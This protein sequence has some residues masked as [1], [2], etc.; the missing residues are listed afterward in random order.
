M[1]KIERFRTATLTGKCSAYNAPMIQ[2]DN[3][4]YVR[5]ESHIEI[6]RGVEAELAALK[7]MQ[8]S[9]FFYH[10]K[11]IFE[12]AFE[13]FISAMVKQASQPVFKVDTEALIAADV[14][15]WMERNMNE[16]AGFATG[17]LFVGAVEVDFENSRVKIDDALIK[18][19]VVG[20]SQ[21]F[22]FPTPKNMVTCTVA[23][24]GMP[25]TIGKNYAFD[26]KDAGLIR[27]CQD[28]M[29]SDL[30]EDD[31]WIAARALNKIDGTLSYE[32]NGLIS[33]RQAS[34]K[35]AK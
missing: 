15:R 27:I 22:P 2:D 23:G 31:C 25:F 5:Y 14:A 20:D 8:K 6:L 30:A 26:R 19:G 34:F 9:D 12:K 3:G 29:V 28:D 7:A 24:V 4:G 33:G 16:R 10:V 18:A 35:I 32:I 21:L 13:D 11:P 17:S 1:K